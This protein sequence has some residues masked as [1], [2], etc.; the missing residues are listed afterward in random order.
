MIPRV[1][2][3]WTIPVIIELLSKGYYESEYF[4]FKEMLPH[5]KDDSGKKRLIKTCCSFANSSGGFLVFGISDNKALSPKDRLVG[6]KSDVDFPEHFGNFPRRCNPSVDW[7]FKNPPLQLPNGNVIHVV[8][9]PRSWNGPHCLG[10]ADNGWIFSKRTNKG[11]EGMTYEE[12]KLNFLGYY[13]KRIK[14]QLLKAELE[15]ILVDA[16]T[17]IIS[18]DKVKTHY[19]LVRFDLSVVESVLTEVYTI[20]A[21]KQE[22]LQLLTRIR[23]QCR[24]INNK[25]EIFYGIVA[26]P[27]SEKD[28]LIESHNQYLNEN[29]TSVF[30]L[31]KEALELLNDIINK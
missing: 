21:E 2:N 14:L 26:M 3:E 15:N 31:T 22:L 7:I 19:S 23:N 9:I 10:E 6:I 18:Q 12:V 16:S 25:I 11:D 4:D 17:M 13:E 30:E 24:R 28:K 5:P 8:Q 27:L 1:L 29:C 20:L